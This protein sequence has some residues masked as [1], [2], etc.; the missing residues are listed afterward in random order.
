M[1]ITDS[2]TLVVNAQVRNRVLVRV[3]INPP[4]L[5]GGGQNGD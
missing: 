3:E 4:G 2:R 5:F 1:R